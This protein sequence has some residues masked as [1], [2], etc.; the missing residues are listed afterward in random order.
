MLAKPMDIKNVYSAWAYK[1]T[2]KY[3]YYEIQ[4][5]SRKID[6][7]KHYSHATKGELFTSGTTIYRLS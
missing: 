3:L 6:T 1:M 7:H 4:F 5:L 2:E